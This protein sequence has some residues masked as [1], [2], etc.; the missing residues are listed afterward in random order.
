MTQMLVDLPNEDIER[1]DQ[2][3]A[4]QGKSIDDV[5]S[6]ITR[7]YRQKVEAAK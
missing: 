6:M 3:A 2:L 5:L 1:L 4:D 7:W